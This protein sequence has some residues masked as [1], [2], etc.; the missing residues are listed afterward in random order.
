MQPTFL[1]L[2][3]RSV[4]KQIAYFFGLIAALVFLSIPAF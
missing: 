1:G 4:V 2:V 3:G